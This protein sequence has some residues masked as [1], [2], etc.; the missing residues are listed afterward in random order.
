MLH[1]T[2]GIVFKTTDYA[3]S[4]IIVQIFTEKFGLQ[5]YLVN[6]I[7]KPKSKVKL[8]FLQPLFLLDLVVYHKP[9][10]NVQRIAEIR[11]SPLL[12]DIPYNIIKSTIVIFLNEVLY[13]SVKQQ[14][15]DQHLF[16]YIFNSI[17]LFDSVEIGAANFHLLFLVKLSRFL[18][19][20]PD[21]AKAG[22]LPFFDLKEGNFTAN[23]PLHHDFIEQRLITKWVELLRTPLSNLDIIN[24]NTK[25]RR[26]F[27][28]KLLTFYNLHLDD[29]RQVKSHI[30]LEE[31][32]S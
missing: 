15:D 19:F 13:K 18:G 6:G 10:G 8:N 11:P 22:S 31:V 24:L 3:E 1:K 2:R 5:S 21:M 20:F 16:D 26:Y 29:F 27:L 25:E 30:I 23:Q 9:G 17:A 7:K 12:T 4:S 32:L 28:D 14:T